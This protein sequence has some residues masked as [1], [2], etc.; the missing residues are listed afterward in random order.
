MKTSWIIGIVVIVLIIGVFLLFGNKNTA[1]NNGDQITPP[2]IP[3]IGENTGVQTY[4]IEIN[5]FAFVPAS[6]NVKA[7]DT[8]I[9]TNK[10]SAPHTVVSDSG[11][12]IGSA[13]LS[14]GNNYSH[15]FN[16]AGTFNYHC[17]IHPGMKANIVVS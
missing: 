9:W 2:P 6:L 11:S 1:T 4:N 12:E 5:N 13:T 3:N 16:T 17:S 8:I 7:G 10:D 15:T 14:Q